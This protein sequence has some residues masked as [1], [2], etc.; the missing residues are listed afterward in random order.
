MHKYECECKIILNP[1]LYRNW[2]GG[3]GLRFFE[4]ST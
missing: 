2:A 1:D 3:I 4:I